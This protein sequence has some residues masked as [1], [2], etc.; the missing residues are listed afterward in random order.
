[1]NSSFLNYQDPIFTYLFTWCVV[2]NGPGR[3]SYLSLDPDLVESD[4]SGSRGDI[5]KKHMDGN[6]RFLATGKIRSDDEMKFSKILCFLEYH[7]L[8]LW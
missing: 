4:G 5:F 2:S 8:R 6:I 7:E 1:M 3:A